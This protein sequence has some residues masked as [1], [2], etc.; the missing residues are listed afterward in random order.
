[1]IVHGAR[2]DIRDGEP[3]RPVLVPHDDP[4]GEFDWNECGVTS[5]GGQC[6]AVAEISSL[7][8]RKQSIVAMMFL[9]N[10]ARAAVAGAA[11]PFG[12]CGGHFIVHRDGKDVRLD[13]E[14]M[15]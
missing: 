5:A 11:V 8:C 13:E 10:W 14:A 1:M 9:P 7:R 6:L 3:V 15:T 4:Y 2:L 12:L